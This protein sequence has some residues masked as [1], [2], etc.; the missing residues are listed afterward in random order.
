MDCM[1]ILSPIVNQG[2]TE[3]EA[4]TFKQEKC[5][6]PNKQPQIFWHIHLLECFLKRRLAL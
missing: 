6:N 1:D 4:R 3:K 2:S 5:G